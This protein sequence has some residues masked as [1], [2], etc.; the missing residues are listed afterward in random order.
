MN[1]CPLGRHGFLRLGGGR[2]GH[3][4]KYRTVPYRTG[5]KKVHINI[6]DCTGQIPGCTE[7]YRQIQGCTNIFGQ[8]RLVIRKFE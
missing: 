3:S 5:Q 6:R 7:L 2:F 1:G 8:I 4:Y